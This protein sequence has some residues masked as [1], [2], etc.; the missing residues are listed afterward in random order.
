MLVL[1]AKAL[2]NGIAQLVFV[3]LTVSRAHHYHGHQLGWVG[4]D[5]FGEVGVI[6]LAYNLVPVQA[7]KKRDH[8]TG[9]LAGEFKFECPIVISDAGACHAEFRD[10]DAFD[11]FPSV[12]VGD[13]TTQYAI[14]LRQHRQGKEKEKSGE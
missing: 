9:F 11:G 13:D 7:G 2:V 6:E 5:G 14:L 8:V 4:A 1:L 12:L 3:G 10:F